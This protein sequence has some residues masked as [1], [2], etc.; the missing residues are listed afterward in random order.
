MRLK[1]AKRKDLLIIAA[2]LAAGLIGMGIYAL[3]N[4]QSPGDR[5]YAEIYYMDELVKV[6]Y[7]DKDLK[8][9]LDQH[10]AIEFEV[11]DGAI[12]FIHSDCPDK[13]CI[14]MGPQDSIGGFAAC[15]PNRTM[16]WVDS[17]ERAKPGA[18]AE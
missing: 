13:I 5:L 4:L 10:P 15:L 3:V 14:M 1:F 9:N 18:P 2:I 12:A 16:L 7:L 6:V 8:F 11:K 17:E